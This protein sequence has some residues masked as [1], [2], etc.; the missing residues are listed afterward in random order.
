[1]DLPQQMPTG[2]GQGTCIRE[3]A[4]LARCRCKC[5]VPQAQWGRTH[6][7]LIDW[8]S[9]GLASGHTES[10]Q[11]HWWYCYGISALRLLQPSPH[12][13]SGGWFFSFVAACFKQKLSL[14][15]AEHRR[16]RAKDVMICWPTELENIGRGPGIGDWWR[17]GLK[18][19]T[20]GSMFLPLLF[21]LKKIICLFAF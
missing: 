18:P 6:A 2:A 9:R 5:S 20:R 8:P 13:L 4:G 1:M 17:Q 10:H 14:Q 16:L 3:I 19:S 15:G 21:F 7:S 11:P 12:F